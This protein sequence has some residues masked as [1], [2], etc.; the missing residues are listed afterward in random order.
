MESMKSVG[1]KQLKARLS[2][3]L[4]MARGGE[5]ILVTDRDEVVA[6]LGPAKRQLAP[7]DELDEIL[8]GL[9]GAGELTRASLP[10]QGWSWRAK[11]LGMPEG[12]ARSLLDEQRAEGE[13]T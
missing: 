10:K 11:G 8:D 13:S 6:E 9:A 12:T 1:V 3:Y 2:E 5:I 4:R 7:A